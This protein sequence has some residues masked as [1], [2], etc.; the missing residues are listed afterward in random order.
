M[1]RKTN[2][3]PFIKHRVGRFQ[4]SVWKRKKIIPPQNGFIPERE[5]DIMRACVQFGSFNKATRTWDNQS[6][7]CKPEELRDLANVL[8]QLNGEDEAYTSDSS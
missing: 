1:T 7:W 5:E 2:R 8:D 3:G 4:I 6:I